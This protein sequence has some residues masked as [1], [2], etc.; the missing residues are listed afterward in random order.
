LEG[1]VEYWDEI[2]GGVEDLVDYKRAG[3]LVD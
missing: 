3:I 2:G 1:E